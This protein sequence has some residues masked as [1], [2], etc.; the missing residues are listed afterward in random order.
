MLIFQVKIIIECVKKL[1]DFLLCFT[2][3]LFNLFQFARPEN[4]GSDQDDNF[5]YQTIKLMRK[6]LKEFA[7]H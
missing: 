3:H 1:S 5:S 7:L 6:L 4:L 2:L